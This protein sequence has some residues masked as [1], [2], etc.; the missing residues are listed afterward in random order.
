MN[1]AYVLHDL[2]RNVR[3]VSS[4]VF[5][6]LLPAALF[7]MFGAIQEWADRSVGHGNVSAHTMVSMAAYGAITATASLAGSAAVEQSQGWGRQLALTP[8]TRGGYVAGKAAV[9]LC[10][11]ALPVLVVHLVGWATNAQIDGAGRWLA[12]ALLAVGGSVVFALYGLTVGLLFRSEAAVGAASGMLV[13]LAFLGNAFVPLSGGLLGF[14]R[15]T[16]VY[17]VMALARYPVTDGVLPVAG[18]GAAPVTDPLWVPVVN[19]VAWTV[20]FAATA[21]LVARRGTSRR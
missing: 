7:L 18:A 1:L 14:S 20:V 6:V 4:M 3:M 21:L 8:L 19:V 2:R 12:T 10:V 13:V 16:P 11:A 15:F 9:A 17:G 5:V